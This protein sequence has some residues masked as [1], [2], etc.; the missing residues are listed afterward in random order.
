MQNL[1][2]SF[3][4]SLKKAVSASAILTLGAISAYAANGKMPIDET[5][6]KL[7]DGRIIEAVRCGVHCHCLVVK[8]GKST[9]HKQC[10]EA[11][12]DRL[13]DY[14]FFVPVKPGRYIFDVNGDG[15]P[16]IGVATWDGGNNIANRY[17]LAFSIQ[18]DKLTYFGREK[19]NLEYG[20][21][22]Y[23]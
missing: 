11:E 13:W 6:I 1:W 10:Y 17:A 5:E 15:S 22:I 20:E 16:E 4:K 9:L 23:K 8:R 14:A 19:F 18:G 3:I 12:F 21:S 2:K 7:S